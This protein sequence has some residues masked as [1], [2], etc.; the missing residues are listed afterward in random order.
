MHH[1][2]PSRSPTSQHLELELVETVAL[3]KTPSS[4]EVLVQVGDLL[5]GLDNGGIDG[6]L[7]RLLLLWE[8]L[9]LLALTEE[10]SL[11]G[12]LGSLGL[13]E[14][15]VVDGLGDRDGGDVDLGGG[16]D[17][18]GLADSSEWDTVDPDC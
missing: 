10:L 5:D 1:V 12:G 14:V 4:P 15:G 6:L 2:M 16:S 17:N 18:V 11:L 13:G 3:G 8:R 7:L 9:L